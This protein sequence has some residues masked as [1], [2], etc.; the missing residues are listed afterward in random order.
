MIDVDAG[1]YKV[2]SAFEFTPSS[3]LLT[4]VLVSCHRR[5]RLGLEI[6]ILVRGH[7][8]AQNY[9]SRPT[10]DASFLRSRRRERSS[11]SRLHI[12]LAPRSRAWPARLSFSTH[13]TTT[14]VV[15]SPTDHRKVPIAHTCRA[16]PAQ[17]ISNAQFSQ[18]ATSIKTDTTPTQRVAVQEDRVSEMRTCRFDAESLPVGAGEACSSGFG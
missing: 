17:G 7:H 1:G 2:R 9:T 8:P 6:P 16:S 14:P 4:F 18:V 3:S 11:G 13:A 5:S 10:K 12:V 15:W